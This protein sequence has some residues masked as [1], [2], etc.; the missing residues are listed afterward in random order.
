MLD[1]LVQQGRL[2]VI[3]AAGGQS[4]FGPGAHGPH[5]VIRLHHRLLPLRMALD[6]MLIVG[7]AY[8]DG[9]LTI[10][11]GNVRD[12]LLLAS[13]GIERVNRMRANGLIKRLQNVAALFAPANTRPRALH[14]VEQHY[15]LPSAFYELF[16]DRDQHYSC[17]YFRTGEEDIETAQQAKVRHIMAKLMLE[18]DS[19]VL[20]IGCGWGS[21]AVAIAAQSGAS[22]QGLTLSVEQ[23][24]TAEA[25][26]RQRDAVGKVQFALRDYRDETG[27]YDRIVSVGMLEH[28]GQHGYAEYFAKVAAMLVDDGVAVIHSIG[29][30]TATSDPGSA[31]FRWLNRHIFPGGY[32]PALSEIMPAVEHAGLWITDIEI[33]R[34]HYADTLRCWWG[35]FAMH[36][37]A[38]QAMLGERFCRMWEF[39]LASCEAGFRNG[40]LMVFQLQLARRIDAVPRT[41]DYIAETEQRLSSQ[42]RPSQA[43]AA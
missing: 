30:T 18:P 24:K 43:R 19:R 36:R 23:L 17:A 22:V 32:I 12:F 4:S 28:V 25:R 35:R 15:D 42:A 7:E 13:A 3:D 31:R 38:A 2:T 6:P 14:N 8:M 16:L 33:L 20:D 9:T 27:R 10:E 11:Q 21:L 1:V 37:S 40:R 29:I 34:L 39:Y 26:A 5:V 41:R